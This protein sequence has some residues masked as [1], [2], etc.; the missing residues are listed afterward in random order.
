MNDSVMSTAWLAELENLIEILQQIN[1]ELDAL[2][3]EE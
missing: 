1:R 3:E 2:L